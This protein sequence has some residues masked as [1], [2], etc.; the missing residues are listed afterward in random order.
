MEKF[1]V[2]LLGV[3]D[4]EGG[5]SGRTKRQNLGPE[6]LQCGGSQMDLTDMVGYGG[7]HEAAGGS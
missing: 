2:G 5:D 1:L 6:V 3:G 7:R 4:D